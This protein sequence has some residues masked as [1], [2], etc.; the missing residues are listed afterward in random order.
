M[1]TLCFLCDV[2]SCGASESVEVE[3][4]LRRDWLPAGWRSDD[5]GRIYCPR[6]ACAAVAEWVR[7]AAGSRAVVLV[8]GETGTGKEVHDV[9]ELA[10]DTRDSL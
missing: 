4:P 10:G 9:P 3:L 2:T 1:I 8:T 5:D 6:E 7:R